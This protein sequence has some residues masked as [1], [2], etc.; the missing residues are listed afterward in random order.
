MCVKKKDGGNFALTLIFAQI[1]YKQ[2]NLQATVIQ[3]ECGQMLWIVAH[4]FCM[5]EVWSLSLHSAQE[6]VV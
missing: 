3:L 1:L 2:K 4:H 5:L 6:F